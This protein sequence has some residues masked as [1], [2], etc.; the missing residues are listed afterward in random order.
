MAFNDIEPI[1][2]PKIPYG[3]R[4]P[5]Q[6]VKAHLISPYSCRISASSRSVD[7]NRISQRGDTPV[8]DSTGPDWVSHRPRTQ[9]MESTKAG[10]TESTSDFSS[11]F[12]GLSDNEI[13][14]KLWNYLFQELDSI[15][16]LY[17][18]YTAGARYG[19]LI[20]TQYIFLAIIIS[21][22]ARYLS[23][24]SISSEAPLHLYQ[25]QPTN[26]REVYKG[27]LDSEWIK[28]AVEHW[29]EGYFVS[30]FKLDIYLELYERVI[31]SLYQ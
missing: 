10:E 29:N 15:K 2:V 6:E 30:P 19:E 22:V 23:Q 16:N 3:G 21:E 18:Y 24:Y 1:L 20:S 25:I 26:I 4:E 5:Y 14:D 11:E 31:K 7:D 13:E 8:I 27:K 12:A 28:L 17:I 9:F